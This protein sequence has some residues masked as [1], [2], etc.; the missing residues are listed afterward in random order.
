MTEH[1]PECPNYGIYIPPD[2]AYWSF[3]IRK[4]ICVAI[5]GDQQ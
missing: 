4:C 1:L 5:K 2:Y 3:Y